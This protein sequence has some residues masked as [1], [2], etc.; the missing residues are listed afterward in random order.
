MWE[1]IQQ[2]DYSPLGCVLAHSWHLMICI[3]AA[4][5]KIFEIILPLFAATNYAELSEIGELNIYLDTFLP[6][7]WPLV[8]RFLPVCALF[9]LRLE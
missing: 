7:L 9:H 8:N 6:C 1:T 3:H 4:H 2:R 5:F